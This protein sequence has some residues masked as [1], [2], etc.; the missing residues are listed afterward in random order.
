MLSVDPGLVLERLLHCCA[1]AGGADRAHLLQDH[2]TG[3]PPGCFPGELQFPILFVE[4]TR[5]CN[6][7]V[8]MLLAMEAVHAP[9]RKCHIREPTH[10]YTCVPSWPLRIWAFSK[11]TLC[12]ISIT[13]VI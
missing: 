4:L 6:L 7:P 2:L 5:S 1:G 11:E 13:L 8:L 10:E 12:F 9:G 3:G